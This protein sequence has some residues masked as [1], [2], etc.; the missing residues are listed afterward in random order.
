MVQEGLRLSIVMEWANTR[1]HGVRRATMLL[2][3]LVRQ[4]QEIVTGEYAATLPPTAT[5]FLDSLDDRAELVIVSGE[6]PGADL[7]KELQGLVSE[8]F[9]FSIHVAEG[10]EYYPLKNVGAGVAAGDLLLFVDSDVLPENGW[11]ANLLGSFGQPGIDVV[12]GQTYVAPT[13]LVA[14]AFALGWTYSLRDDAGRLVQPRKFYANNIVF[15]TDVFRRVGFR[16]VGRRSRGASSLLREDLEQ[17]GVR[18]WENR[19]AR[20]DH[21]PPTS[22]RHMVVRALAHGRDHYMKDSEERSWDGMKRSLGT[23]ASRL[24]RGFRRTFRNWRRIGLR[25]HQIPAVL[26]IIVTYYG[27]FA[28]GGLLTHIHPKS[29]GRHFR[30]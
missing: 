21:P 1:L 3:T 7:A 26:I 9:V 8:H 18:V 25:R 27:F 5:R 22:F 12:C 20:V 6:A 2:D 28:M 10:L 30:V 17:L 14:R 11:L 16:S 29:M 15:R 23:A 4:W 24:S 19:A 13:D